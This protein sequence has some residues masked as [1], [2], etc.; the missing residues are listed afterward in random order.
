MNYNSTLFESDNATKFYLIG[1]ILADGFISEDLK[2]V[3]IGLSGKDLPFLKTVRDI[4]C[5][6]QNIRLS[7]KSSI[8]GGPKKH[9]VA[10]LAINSKEFVAEVMKYCNTR[11]KTTDLIFP[12]N[13]PDDFLL[14][15][16][17]G[18]SD[19]DGNISVKKGQRK[20]NEGISYYHG[21]RYRILGTRQFLLG[22]DFSL[23]RLEL[24]RNSVNPH[25]KD[26][27]NCYYI[28]YGFSS[29]QRIL[30]AIY[31]D[32]TL[33]MERKYQVYNFIRNADS[34]QLAANYGSPD[35]RYNTLN[36]PKSEKKI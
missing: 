24:A 26:Q 9:D 28:E 23:R 31:K 33:K 27:S 2:R 8:T 16:I 25:K 10:T 6:Q 30:D 5:P 29:A 21:L 17:R 22:L 36:P 19:G 35:G 32:A 4:I 3:T 7:K 11:K 12:T 13:I 18:Y 14:D 15:F 34:K 20:T 1:F